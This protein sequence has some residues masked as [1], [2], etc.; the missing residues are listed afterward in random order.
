MKT[1]RVINHNVSALLCKIN[2]LEEKLYRTNDMV[3]KYTEGEMTLA[4][5]L[6]IKEQRKAWREEINTLKSQIAA[7]KAQG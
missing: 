4:E 6:P 5:Y 7:E 2:A 1:M 3:I